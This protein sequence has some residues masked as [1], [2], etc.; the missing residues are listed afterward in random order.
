MKNNNKKLLTIYWKHS[1]FQMIAQLSA[2]LLH[3]IN[4]VWI[5]RNKTQPTPLSI[6]QF[7]L[8]AREKR[9]KQSKRVHECHSTAT[10]KQ[11]YEI[12]I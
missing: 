12:I 1:K 5:F 2:Y 6:L 4:N 7:S 3:K 10:N 9:I 11:I 8:L